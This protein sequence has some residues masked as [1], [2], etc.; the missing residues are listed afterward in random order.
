MS[1]LHIQALP[2][3][4]TQI[5]KPLP[6]LNILQL[7]LKWMIQYQ[8]CHLHWHLCK[9]TTTIKIKDRV[10]TTIGNIFL[11]I[12]NNNNG[13]QHPVCIFI[14]VIFF[15]SFKKA[16]LEVMAGTGWAKNHYS[17]VAAPSRSEKSKWSKLI[18]IWKLVQ[19]NW[20]LDSQS[21]HFK[22]IIAIVNH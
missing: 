15:S 3:S 19:A 8:N 12:I 10:I 4:R 5:T 17:Q 11:N 21:R 9:T 22:L 20:R 2:R 14:R 7:H 16:R 13:S 1:T 18:T 6:Q